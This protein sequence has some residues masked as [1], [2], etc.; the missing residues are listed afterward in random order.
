MENLKDRERIA[1]ISEEII[2]INNKIVGTIFKKE[3][4]EELLYQTKDFLLKD[5]KLIKSEELL[6]STNQKTIKEYSNGILQTEIVIDRYGCIFYKI[7]Y[8]YDSNGNKILHDMDF[9][10]SNKY[11]TEFLN[12]YDNQSRLVKKESYVNAKFEYTEDICY[13]SNNNVSLI[14]RRNKENIEIY[15]RNNYYNYFNQI[16]KAIGVDNEKGNKTRFEYLTEYNPNGDI[17]V[18]T[19]SKSGSR[20]ISVFEYKY[21]YRS[22]WIEKKKIQD[23]KLSQIFKRRIRYV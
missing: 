6:I 11:V 1:S 9:P 4:P 13:D 12:Y 16:Y 10:G 20:D 18:Y 8:K 15:K 7:I 14:W 21:D 5:G 3:V 2:N 23:G 19:S 17:S 22:N